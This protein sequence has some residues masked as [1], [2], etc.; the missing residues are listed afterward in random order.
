MV[1]V[2]SVSIGCLRK[3]PKIVGKGFHRTVYRLGRFAFK[4]EKGRRGFKELHK[5]AVAADA[6]HR[7][8]RGELSF[9][10]EYYGT[11]IM[12]VKEKGETIPTFATFH[13]Y[14]RPLP[15][16]SIDALA[17]VLGI[18]GEAYR[19]G[20]F[21]DLKPSNFG[22]R[23]KE[24]LYLDEYGL[25]KSPIPPDVLEDLRNLIEAFR[26]IVKKSRK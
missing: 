2:G 1:A 14:A 17:G 7:R 22:R 10:P 25:G 20:Y 19:K 9:L 12:A 15:R 13:D 11:V 26:R 8:I 4:V 21:P 6:Y 23:G 18:L 3:S 24:I 5:R 16:F